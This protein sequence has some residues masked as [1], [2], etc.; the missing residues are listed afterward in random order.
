MAL[1]R[2]ALTLLGC[3]TALTALTGSA[4]TITNT[5]SHLGAS[6]LAAGL[7]D[8][9]FTITRQTAYEPS[10][11]QDEV[12]TVTVSDIDGSACA[13]RTLK[14]VLTDASQNV[15]GSQKTAAVA[16]SDIAK[17]L[18]F[19]TDNI[20]AVNVAATHAVIVQP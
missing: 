18:D 17:T 16:T 11:G 10:L 14:V 19:S 13:G 4:A 12:T 20:P 15:L 1:M 3:I 7:C 5:V 2:L 8:Q 9:T 6:S